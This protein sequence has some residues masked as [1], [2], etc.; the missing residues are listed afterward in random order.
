[1]KD[2]PRSMILYEADT[3]R[4]CGGCTLCCK[5][6]PV[7]D[8]AVGFHK[9][10]NTR[11][12]HQRHGKGC[13]IYERKPPSCATYSCR[14]LLGNDTADMPRPDRAHYVIDPMPDYISVVARDTGELQQHIPVVQVWIDPGYPDAHRDPALRRYLLRRGE[15][16]VA[17]VIRIEA[18]GQGFVLVPPNMTDSHEWIEVRDGMCGPQ[19]SFTDYMKASDENQKLAA[20]KGNKE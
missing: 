12:Q 18:H 5:L 14:W 1:M 20:A 10:G 7:H 3:A 9:E 15:E 6:L 17:A 16:G 8:K 11:C 19:H 13:T 2:V 4:A